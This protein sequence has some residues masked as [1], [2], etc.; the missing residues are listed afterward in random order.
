[1]SMRAIVVRTR[2]L[3]ARVDAGGIG[4]RGTRDIKGRER[5]TAV[6]ETMGMEMRAIVVRT[7]HL[8]ARVDAG[9]YGVTGTRDIEAFETIRCGLNIGDR[10]THEQE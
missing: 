4:V 3:S 10:Q 6:H 5:T 9:W 1:M 7:R 8:S 2:H